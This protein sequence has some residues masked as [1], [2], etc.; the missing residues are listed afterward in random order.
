MRIMEG[1]RRAQLP[2]KLPPNDITE[3]DGNCYFRAV[4]S[5]CQRPEVAAPDDIKRLDHRAMRKKICN[6]MMKSRLP[7]VVDFRKRW[8][9]F[10]L[11]DYNQYWR[12]MAESNGEIWA[13]G[14]V[15]HATAWCLERHINIVSEQATME[16]PLLSFSGN[17]DGSE[18]SCAGAPMWL[19]H[20]TGLHYQTLMPDEN[21]LMPPPTRMQNIEDT[22]KL[23]AKGTA[24][25]DQ[26]QRQPGTSKDSGVGKVSLIHC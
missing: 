4:C 20:L 25:G 1:V 13:E 16:D 14:P 10:G 22:L 17:Q 5:Q 19:G 21:E 18:R 26:Q 11:G 6:F 15:I 3:G 24:D 9:A 23:K 8:F 12:D 7:V 2:L